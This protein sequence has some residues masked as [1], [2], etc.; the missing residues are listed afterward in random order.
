MVK[1]KKSKKKPKKIKKGMKT[2]L[3][4]PGEEMLEL[5]EKDEDESEMFLEKEDVQI[6]FNA[7]NKYKPTRKEEQRYELLL[8]SFDE[9]LVVDYDE[10]PPDVN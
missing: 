10:A 2:R 1:A 6:I 7:L 5:D 9:I 4:L 8:E 3:I